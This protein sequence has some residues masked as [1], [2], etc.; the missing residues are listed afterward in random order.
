MLMSKLLG[1]RYK[2]APADAISASHIFLVRGGYIRQVSNGV[3]SLLMP[4]KRVMKK[5]EKII[6]E[7]M[8]KID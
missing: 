5:I 3:F 7:E 4:A 1:E 8:D 6:R 2:E